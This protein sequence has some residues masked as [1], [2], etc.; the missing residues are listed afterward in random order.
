MNTN[1]EMVCPFGPTPQREVFWNGVSVVWDSRGSNFLSRMYCVVGL[2]VIG[3]KVL[4]GSM[5]PSHTVEGTW[6][7][8]FPHTDRAV[9][10]RLEERR[11][12]N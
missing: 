9:L 7:L 5:P 11:Y 3:W 1:N 2:V 10:S 12:E 6:M 8:R 4:L